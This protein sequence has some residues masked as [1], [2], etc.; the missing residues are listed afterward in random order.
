[1]ALI[2][3]QSTR[4]TKNWCETCDRVK[5]VATG[6]RWTP[7]SESEKRGGAG[8]T[9]LESDAAEQRGTRV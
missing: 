5:A 7:V 9:G 4:Q 8:C 3:A 1:M 2:A 6:V